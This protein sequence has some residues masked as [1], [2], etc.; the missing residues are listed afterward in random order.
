MPNRQRRPDDEPPGVPRLHL[1]ARPRRL[2][3]AERHLAAIDAWASGFAGAFP[4]E[5]THPQ[6]ETYSLPADMRLTDRPTTR[7]AYQAR[8]ANAL[9]FAAARLRA[10]R[11]PGLAHRKI[12]VM[13]FQPDM[14]MSEVQVFNDPG[15]YRT[16]EVRT[17]HYQ[18]WTRLPPERSLV[19]E[20]G[21]VLPDG[22]VERGWLDTDT[23]EDPDE[24]SGWR[25]FTGEVWMIGEPVPA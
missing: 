21:L 19:Q 8:C 23:N 15:Y 17:G 3:D 24:A 22:F 10:A 4:E 12:A 14:F 2:R 5:P 1:A 11:P 6:C 9:L 13:I 25:V 18:V 20:L 7:P 16:F